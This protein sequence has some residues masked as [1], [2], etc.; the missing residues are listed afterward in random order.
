MREASER[1]HSRKLIP[2][3]E[4]LGD[5][6]TDDDHMRV[7]SLLITLL[8]IALETAPVI[9]KLLLHRTKYDEL[10]E[11]K[12]REEGNNAKDEAN[13]RFTHLHDLNEQLNENRKEII[14]KAIEYISN[15]KWKKEA[16]KID[17]EAS[18]KSFVERITSVEL[19]KERPKGIFISRRSLVY[20]LLLVPL[21][22][23]L[24]F[25]PKM[26]GKSSDPGDK[27]EATIDINHPVDTDEPALT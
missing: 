24:Y 8:F 6:T 5:L 15:E 10:L 11:L 19:A 1:G 22:L 16:E 23:I 26:I 7:V 9:S 20:G 4:A 14:G 13:M 2:Y 27:T 25:A 3:L 12:E 18:F 17:S 21:L